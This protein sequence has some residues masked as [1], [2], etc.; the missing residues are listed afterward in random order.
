MTGNILRRRPC[1]VGAV[2]ARARQDEAA[3]RRALEGFDVSD[4]F[5][6]VTR[7]QRATH[8]ASHVTVTWLVT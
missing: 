3:A 4:A 5:N 2:C 1:A 6:E 8:V 7:P